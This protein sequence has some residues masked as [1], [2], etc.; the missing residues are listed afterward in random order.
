MKKTREFSAKRL[1]LGMHPVSGKSLK[2][3][4]VCVP[5]RPSPMTD[6]AVLPAGQG[7]EVDSCPREEPE[8]ALVWQAIGTWQATAPGL[9]EALAERP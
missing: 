5:Q 2:V 6:L 4:F 1:G 9:L 3:S 7:V 8:A